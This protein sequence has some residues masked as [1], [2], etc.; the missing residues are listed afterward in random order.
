MLHTSTTLPLAQ[1]A[2]YFPDAYLLPAKLELADLGPSRF[3]L[4]SV[5]EILQPSQGESPLAI[6]RSGP[7][8][9][10]SV[11][12]K[13]GFGPTDEDDAHAAA[14]ATPAALAPG[15]PTPI[16]LE[17]GKKT[18]ILVSGPDGMIEAVSGPQHS[19]EVGG[20]LAQLGIKGE[21]VEVRRFWN[22]EMPLRRAW[23][24]EPELE[25]QGLVRGETGMNG[26]P[27]KQPGWFSR[28]A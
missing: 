20:I 4:E 27:P 15:R 14:L 22:K 28:P 24:D 13:L 23:V 8:L 25:V 21:G 5:R 11:L 10:A 19:K 26:Q 16:V 6:A 3:S 7:G 2:P 12:G 17:D 9:L 1:L 18:L